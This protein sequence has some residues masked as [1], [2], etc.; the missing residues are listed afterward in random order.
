MA[1]GVHTT[2]FDD[3]NSFRGCVFGTNYPNYYDK[4][5]FAVRAYTG[6]GRGRH[7]GRASFLIPAFLPCRYFACNVA[8]QP[9]GKWR[10]TGD[11]GYPRDFHFRGQILAAN[12]SVQDGGY[13]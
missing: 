8:V 5:D 3:A 11:G 4:A 9:S 6:G 7:P 2:V 1:R 10:L 12:E 13:N